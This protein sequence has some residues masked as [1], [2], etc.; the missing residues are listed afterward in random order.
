[1]MMLLKSLLIATCA[2]G[3]APSST[4]GHDAIK[5][6]SPVSPVSRRGWTT[7]AASAA[8]AAAVLPASSAWAASPPGGFKAPPIEQPTGTINV[9][10]AQASQYMDCPGMY[11]TIA[12]RIVEHVRYEGRFKSIED[13]LKAEDVTNGNENIVNVIKKNAARLVVS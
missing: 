13:L 6:A 5:S 1:M 11:P 4:K 2:S 12:S 9:N 10:T 8:V 7:G 3:L